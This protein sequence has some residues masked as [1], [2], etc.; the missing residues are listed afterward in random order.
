MTDKQGKGPAKGR[1][2]G[3]GAKA[4]LSAV[5]DA[6]ERAEGQDQSRDPRDPPP[7]E[8]RQSSAAPETAPRPKPKPEPRPE[9][10]PA[11]SM[12]ELMARAQV[13]WLGAGIRYWS[14][15]AELFGRRGVRI[16]DMAR[17]SESDLDERE[18]LRLLDEARGYLREVGEISMREARALTDDMT[19][20]EQALRKTQA[21]PPRPTPKRDGR[22]SR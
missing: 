16:A 12:A 8:E 11:E 19:K 6:F 1:G 22:P 9:V 15:M 2:Q 4:L 14:E 3:Q 20:L 18:K 7:E 17:Y 13:A 10:E 21:K 5:P